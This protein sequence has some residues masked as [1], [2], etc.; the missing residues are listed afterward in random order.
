MRLL[1]KVWHLIE[2]I[3]GLLLCHELRFVF[4]RH[5]LR[6]EL[7]L[8]FLQIHY[9]WHHVHLWSIS[10][11]ILK[12]FFWLLGCLVDEV[13]LKVHQIL[14]MHDGRLRF[15]DKVARSLG[16]IWMLWQSSNIL[17]SKSFVS[18]LFRLLLF[19]YNF[20][21]LL[22]SFFLLFRDALASA[23]CLSLRVNSLSRDLNL[24]IQAFSA[25]SLCSCIRRERLNNISNNTN[26]FI[27]SK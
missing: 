19:I 10:R 27:D 14:S 2:H 8:I 17:P 24:N 21:Y 7:N 23:F 9:V 11:V 13:S 4:I 25:C 22:R 26:I 6:P 5:G 15:R 3:R 1:P 12:L 20:D 16:L 18:V